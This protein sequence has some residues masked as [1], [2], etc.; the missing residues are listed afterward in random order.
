MHSS[1]TTTHL[2]TP[3][4]AA[5]Y[6][7][8]VL[9]AGVLVLPGLAV[10]LAGPASLIAWA[11]DSALGV[12]LA[13]LFAAL[14]TRYPGQAGVFGFVRQGLGPV[15][16][17][18]AGWS[19]FMAATIGQIIVPLSG[20]VYV[21]AAWHFG[22]TGVLALAE[23]ILG[24]AI[25]L[26]LRGLRVSGAVQIVLIVTVVSVLV[27]T[28]A[29][30]LAHARTERLDPFWLHGWL[31]VAHTAT[32]LFFAFS[33]WEVIAS[34]SGEFRDRARGLRTAT[35][36]ALI[37]VTVLYLGISGAVVLGLPRSLAG[38]PAALFAIWR[39]TLGP[40]ASTVL[41]LV[42]VCLATGTTNAFIAGASRLGDRLAFPRRSPI[43]VPHTMI[44][45]I[46]A[47][48]G[49]G[50]LVVTLARASL[51]V[52]LAA[53]SG[54]V[55]VTYL[56]CAIAGWRLL[57]GPTRWAAGLA[58]LATLAILPFVPGIPWLLAAVASGALVLLKLPRTKELW[59]ADRDPEFAE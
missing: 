35:L 14:G 51:T 36:I 21:G 40:T 16:G 34:L 57:A 56:L 43:A 8:A 38:S 25:L 6:L 4:G 59:S 3:V 28:A 47:F 12:V 27:G 58:A 48:A 7:G 18:V 37:A 9:G 54:L 5:L 19:Y 45:V 20:A 24:V 17:A 30:G 22:P 53:S 32:V 11:M 50:I 29:L 42:A 33:G 10:H 49:L 55:L 13:L 46:G 1:D 31:G 52:P 41:S 26:N 15:V 39:R 23:S 44:W 2:S